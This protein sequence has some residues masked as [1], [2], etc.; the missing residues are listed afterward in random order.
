MRS[1]GRARRR[2][3][4]NQRVS[5]GHPVAN[6]T[7]PRISMTS[8]TRAVPNLAD[9]PLHNNMLRIVACLA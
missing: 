8:N 6:A 7:S 4:P 2:A 9:I 5:T 1:K 3:S